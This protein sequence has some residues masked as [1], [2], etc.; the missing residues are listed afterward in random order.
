MSHTI[1]TLTEL[2]KNNCVV[3]G[4]PEHIYHAFEA[5][6]YSG[7]KQ[8]MKAPGYFRYYSLN[9]DADED[10]A[11][12]RDNRLLHMALSE[13]ER[14][15]RDVVVVE[16]N[17]NA[18]D[19]K[20]AIAK[21]VGEGKTVT[22]QATLDEVIEILNF[23][24]EHPITKAILS[25]G[26]GE[27]TLLWKDPATG[28]QCKGRVDWLR[29]DG[30][31]VDWKHFDDLSPVGIERQIRRMKYDLQAAWYTEGASIIFGRPIT[32]FVNVFL[33]KKYPLDLAARTIY[34][35]GLEEARTRYRVHL[36][37]Y[38]TCLKEN[39]WSLTPAGIE[40]VVLQQYFD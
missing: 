9:P 28:V 5:M 4:V 8:F 24:H 19:V 23:V 3:D 35:H 34:D 15:A 2:A 29:E 39:T 13:P 32:E 7:L 31:L 6:S 25:Q 17:R 10:T 40:Q 36:E 33:R 16:G 30:I 21:A 27:Q 20:A 37:N 1:E 11:S 26:R 18:N 14:F 12:R 38:A 22:K